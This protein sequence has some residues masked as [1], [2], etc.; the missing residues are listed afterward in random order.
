MLKFPKNEKKE[1]LFWGYVLH[2]FQKKSKTGI[3]T[4]KQDVELI[5]ELLKQ[6]RA[7]L[8]GMVKNTTKDIKQSSGNLYKDLGYKNPE[9]MEARAILMR[10]IYKIIT[11]KNL[12]QIEAAE[13]LDIPQSTVSKL[14]SGTVTGFSTD[15]LLRFLKRL[16]V[17]V[18][19]NVKTSKRKQ[20]QGRLSVSYSSERCS[21]PMAAKGM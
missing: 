9:E 13:L 8:Q 12:T 6:A 7:T 14:M 16:G 18:N 11:K 4:D 17:D 5:R 10:E 3:K 21:V 15:R 20:G 2:A 19:I 1:K